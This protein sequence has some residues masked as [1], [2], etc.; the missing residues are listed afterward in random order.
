[1][2]LCVYIYSVAWVFVLANWVFLSCVVV[3]F[4]LFFYFDVCYFIY[5]Y[6][7]FILLCVYIH[8]GSVGCYSIFVIFTEWISLDN[9]ELSALINLHISNLL[10]RCCLVLNVQYYELLPTRSTQHVS[11]E[12]FTLCFNYSFWKSPF[13]Y[14]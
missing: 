14:S 10:S 12:Y 13:H 3:A 2:I 7:H 1:M 5:I 11:V 4:S 6:F 9:I 8:F